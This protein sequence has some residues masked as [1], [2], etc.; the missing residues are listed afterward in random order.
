MQEPVTKVN[1]WI[2]FLG[3]CSVV[4]VICSVVEVICSV[5]EVVCSV[6]EVVCSVVEVV[7]SGVEVV[8]SVVVVPSVELT[9]EVFGVLQSSIEG[10]SGPL[11]VVLIMS[12]KMDT[13]T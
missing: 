11:K 13:F 6:V 1:A 8:C 3:T 2:F 5:D 12:S 9:V 7:C 4:E 10:E